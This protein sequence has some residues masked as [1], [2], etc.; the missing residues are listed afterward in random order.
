MDNEKKIREVVR[1][2]IKEILSEKKSESLSGMKK[3]KDTSTHTEPAKGVKA[4]K[5]TKVTKDSPPASVTATSEVKP[6]DTGVEVKKMKDAEEPKKSSGDK[7]ETTCYGAELVVNGSSHADINHL[8][9]VGRIKQALE[10]KGKYVKKITIEMGEPDK[11][12]EVR[13]V[14]REHIKNILKESAG[15]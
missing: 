4:P 6:D 13:K 2:L 3:M 12:E 15:K 1:S 10:G 8:L 11:L 5:T 9:M 7:Y 14:V